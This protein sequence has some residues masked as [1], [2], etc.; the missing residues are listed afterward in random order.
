M[1]NISCLYYL[2]KTLIDGPYWNFKPINPKG[3]QPWILIGRIDAEAE[4]PILWPPDVNSWL[5]G[6][7]PDAGKDWRQKE[8][9]WQSMILLDD[10]TDAMDMNKG[11]LW[12]MMRDR[13]AW[14]AVVHGIMES[15]TQLG[16]W[17]TIGISSP[18][19]Y[20]KFFFPSHLIISISLLY[21]ESYRFVSIGRGQGS[22]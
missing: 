13:E 1:S 19:L 2:N 21:Q 20:R 17:T 8:K 3:N 22:E 6:K 18:G 9:W 14:C 10:I 16:N 4:A 7:D 15:W 11:V 5:I 12:E